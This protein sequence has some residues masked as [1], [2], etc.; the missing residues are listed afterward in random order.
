MYTAS[1]TRTAWFLRLQSMLRFPKTFLA[2]RSAMVTRARQG[3]DDLMQD[4]SPTSPTAANPLF[5]ARRSY[6]GASAHWRP[7][8]YRGP[9]TWSELRPAGATAAASLTGNVSGT[10]RHDRSHVLNPA[11]ARTS[12]P[13]NSFASGTAFKLGHPAD[14]HQ[15][16]PSLAQVSWPAVSPMSRHAHGLTEPAPATRSWTSKAGM[17]ESFSFN[18]KIEPSPRVP[19]P[20]IAEDGGLEH[21]PAPESRPAS[22][23]IHIDAQSDQQQPKPPTVSTVHIDGS[24]LG[25]WAIQHLERTLAKPPSGMTGVDPRAS[26]PRGRV[27]P[28]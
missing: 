8:T 11:I 27:S 23:D 26:L 1:R 17:A 21:S 22:D 5:S 9:S 19:P 25:R 18:T 2:P 12:S 7:N 10:K 15:R 4:R 6:S 14:G 20:S 28:F 16:E 13:Q 24:A 3:A